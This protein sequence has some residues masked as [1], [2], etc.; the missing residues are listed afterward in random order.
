MPESLRT[1]GGY[2][3]YGKKAVDR[4]RL[5]RRALQL[6]FSLSELS[7]ILKVRDGGGVPCRRVLTL[8]EEKLRSLEQQI[9]QLRST[10][11][12]MKQIVRQWR[13]K[14]G[15]TKGSNMA[16]LLE[17]LADRPHAMADRSRNL[18]RR[19]TI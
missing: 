9:N 17:S 10:Q 1:S 4:V 3:M 18:T 13:T 5:V 8:T 19:K 2:R 12:Y 11:R 16:M 14:L 7:E 6:G 15:R